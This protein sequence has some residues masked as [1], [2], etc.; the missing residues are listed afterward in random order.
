MPKAGGTTQVHADGDARNTRQRP[1]GTC[2]DGERAGRSRQARGPCGWTRAR[3][4]T[5][6]LYIGKCS[7]RLLHQE[8]PQQGLPMLLTQPQRG[9]PLRRHALSAQTPAALQAGAEPH[10]AGHAQRPDAIPE[11]AQGMEG[12]STREPRAAGPHRSAG[13]P[14][15]GRRV[16]GEGPAAGQCGPG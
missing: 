2:R 13:P 10:Q 6:A 14:S 15:G 3:P 11:G 12:G 1:R 7:L 4:R 16:L 8:L 9:T 5:A